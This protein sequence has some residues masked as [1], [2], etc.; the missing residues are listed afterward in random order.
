MQVL[1]F[2]QNAHHVPSRNDWLA[3]NELLRLSS[4]SV[5]KRR[6]DWRLGRWTAKCAVATY[7]QMS[8]EDSTLASIEICPTPSGAPEVHISD[9]ALGLAISLS[10]STGTAI[11]ALSQGDVKLGC[12]VE[13]IE[14]R[15]DAFLE[16]YFTQEEQA[17]VAD[18][19]AYDRSRLV[20]FLWSAKESALKAMKQGLRLDTRSVIVQPREP[21]NEDH[22]ARF[23]VRYVRGDSFS[24]WCLFDRTIVRTFV[25][26]C[27]V[28]EPLLLQMEPASKNCCA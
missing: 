22:W 27:P 15:A 6:S 24:G 18:A 10:H 28:D 8:L 26:D 11:C 12:D 7:L 14:P 21:M 3:P 20:T 13:L 4:F 23:S 9:T 5:P 19:P 17:L 25:S 16:D 2:E 1:W